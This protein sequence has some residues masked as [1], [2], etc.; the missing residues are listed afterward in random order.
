MTLM[1]KRAELMPEYR[2]GTPSRA[3]MFLTASA[4]LV[5]ARLDSTWA[6]VESVM[7]GYLQARQSA[8]ASSSRA[9]EQPM[10]YVRTM[11]RMPPPAPARAWATLS[12]WGM[13]VLAAMADD[14][15][16]SCS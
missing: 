9:A 6:R 8:R 10:P 16:Y 14:G 11:D 4:N 2:P 12:F 3:M 7:R 5:S 13:G 15:G 1:P